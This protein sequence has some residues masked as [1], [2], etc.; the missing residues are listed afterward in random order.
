MLMKVLFMAK[1]SLVLDIV[2]SHLSLKVTKKYPIHLVCKR[3]YNLHTK[4]MEYNIARMFFSLS[5]VK[6]GATSTLEKSYP[7]LNSHIPYCC[8]KKICIYGR[9]TND[10]I[11][12][13]DVCAI[14]KVG[15]VIDYFLG[16]LGV[17]ITFKSLEIYP[18]NAFKSRSKGRQYI[19][20]GYGEYISLRTTNVVKF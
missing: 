16:L 13:N 20:K 18:H 5:P 3:I 17:N 9:V 15:D 7:R 12:T 10:D 14:G 1:M 2:V 4:T 11:F 8:L 19:S 6:G